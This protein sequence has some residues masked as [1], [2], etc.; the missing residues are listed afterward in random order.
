MRRRLWLTVCL[1]DLKASLK[2]ASEPI[3]SPDE[4]ASTFSLPK[5]IND[6]DF[7]PSTSNEVPEREELTDTTFALVTYH[8]QLAGRALNFDAAGSVDDKQARLKHAE[9]FEHNALRLLHFCDPESSPFAWF[10]WHGTQCLVSGARLSSLRPLKRPQVRGSR[11]PAPSESYHA[12]EIS[13]KVLHLTLKVLEKAQLMHTD[14][15]GEGFRWYVTIPWHAVAT[16]VTESMTCGDENLVRLAWPII[17]ASYVLLQTEGGHN[18]QGN[19]GGI[20]SQL[21]TLMAQERNKLGPVLQQQ[22]SPCPSLGFGG[23]S[24]ATSPRYND[25]LN[26]YQPSAICNRGPTPG[27]DPLLLLPFDVNEKPD[28]VQEPDRCPGWDK[29]GHEEACWSCM[30]LC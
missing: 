10:T 8:L 22:A 15:R 27:L 11:T 21:E 26:L 16:A 2:Q 7:D 29:I 1:L 23:S 24:A 18:G 25:S 9:R 12:S 20:H 5:N 13:T 19:N 6:S 4:A 3:I 17:E 28:A 30:F 14:P